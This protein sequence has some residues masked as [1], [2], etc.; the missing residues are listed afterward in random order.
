MME[1]VESF[2]NYLTEG[3]EENIEGSEEKTEDSEEKTEDLKNNIAI[4]LEKNYNRRHYK[5]K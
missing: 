3:S 2:L 1:E 4:C 5:K